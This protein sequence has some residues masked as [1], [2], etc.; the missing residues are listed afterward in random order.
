MLPGRKRPVMK[1]PRES[2]TLTRVD[3]ISEIQRAVASCQASVLFWNFMYCDSCNDRHM[4]LHS[5]GVHTNIPPLFQHKLIKLI[6][7]DVG[8]DQKMSALL[9]TNP[10]HE[11]MIP[12]GRHSPCDQCCGCQQSFLLDLRMQECGLPLLAIEHMMQSRTNRCCL[13]SSPRLWRMQCDMWAGPT[14]SNKNCT[15]F[16]RWRSIFRRR[17]TLGHVESLASG[18]RLIQHQGAF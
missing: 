11:G 4:G 7:A 3:I 17:V 10:W 15:N 9:A 14:G 6:Y 5:Q 18:P 12:W 13:E 16:A 8:F 1:G 2:S